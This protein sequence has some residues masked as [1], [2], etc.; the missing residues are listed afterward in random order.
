M[1][2]GEMCYVTRDDIGCKVICGCVGCMVLY[3]SVKM[4]RYALVEDIC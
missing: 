4:W 2:C 3:G 1:I